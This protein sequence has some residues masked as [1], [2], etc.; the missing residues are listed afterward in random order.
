MT[1][2][3]KL[4]KISIPKNVIENV[5]KVFDKIKYEKISLEITSDNSLFISYHT[6]D[7]VIDIDYYFNDNDINTFVFI[8]E[9]GI[10]VQYKALH[11][12]DLT[13]VIGLKY[14]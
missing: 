7:Y 2:E 3:D 8:W 10:M 1:L 5:I 13:T 9:N 4:L 12:E 11:F 14:D 6:K